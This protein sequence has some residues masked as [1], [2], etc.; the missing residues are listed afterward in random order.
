MKHDQTLLDQLRNSPSQQARVLAGL[1]DALHWPGEGIQL[2]NALSGSPTAMDSADLLNSLRNLG[3]RWSVARLNDP[4]NW[5]ER[6]YP[7]LVRQDEAGAPFQLV[8]TAEQLREI[9]THSSGLLGYRF[10][11]EPERAGEQRQWFQAQVMRFRRGIGELYAASL[12]LNLLA[13]VLPFFIRAVYNL[14]IPG[15]Q[16]GD[17]FLLLPFA[18]L[19]VGLQIALTQWRQARLADYGAQLDL[20]LATR[21]LGKLLRMRLPQLERYSPLALAGRLRGYQGLRTYVT[22]PLSLAALDLPFIVIYLAAIA[23]MSVPLMGLTILMVVLCFGGVWAV[24]SAGRAVQAPLSLNPSDLEPMLLDL[25]QNFDQVKAA[26]AERLWQQRLEAASADQAMQGIAGV[27]LQQLIGILT[28]EFSQLTGALVLAAG[29]ALALAGDALELGTLIA[30]MFF[31]WRVFRPIQVAYQ[32]LSRWS[33]MQPTLEQLNRFMASSD[34]EPDSAL[35][36]H[37]LLPDPKGALAFKTVNLRLNAVQEAALSQMSFQIAAGSLAV[38]SGVEGAGSSSILK[39]IDGQIPAGSGVITLDGADLRQ[40]PLAQLRQAIAYLPEQ[41][42][43]FPGS[44]R[45][46]LLLANPLLSDAELEAGLRRMGVEEL[47]DGA[48]LN[49]PVALRGSDGLLPHQVQAVAIARVLLTEPVVLLL[50]HPFRRLAAPNRVALLQELQNRRG[51]AT[52]L[53][54]SDSPEL[55]TIADQ[56]LILKEGSLAFSGTPA[57]L[58]AAQQQAQA[59]MAQSRRQV[60]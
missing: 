3:Y 23:S 11:F 25:V 31:V 59:A 20:I 41:G 39:L 45:E 4:A 28:G 50:D 49:R 6:A 7:I 44:L 51:R 8:E 35:T 16:V 2:R 48:G 24:A 60:S 46:N 58:L 53:V 55:L 1:L 38:L 40:Y 57:E 12:L 43:V 37:W 32:A 21:V 19:A 36:Q 34:V 30:A 14:E 22:G 33:L 9:S 29:T 27:R 13:L 17:L 18:L 26:G 10:H 15:G 47:L 54:A 5:T 42:V 56:I 52:T